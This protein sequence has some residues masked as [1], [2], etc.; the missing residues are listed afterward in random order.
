MLSYNRFLSYV[1]HG[2]NEE[3]F[4]PITDDPEYD[5]FVS[6]YKSKTGGEFFI[7]WT[8]RNIRRK[9]PSDVILAFKLFCDMLPKEEALKCVLMLHTDPVDNNGTDLPAVIDAI[10]PEYKVAFSPKKVD[11]KT[12]NYMYNLASA[13]INISYAEGWGLSSHESLMA[14]T[15][16]IGNVTGGIQDQ[17]GFV[18]E[19]GELVDPSD[20]T[21][22]WQTNADGK[23]TKHGEWCIALFPKIRT[24][25]GSP[26]TPYIY[27]DYCSVN[28]VADAIKSIYDMPVEERNRLGLLGR[29][30]CLDERTGMSSK[31]MCN[32]MIKCIDTLYKDYTKFIKSAD[33]FS[34][35]KVEYNRLDKKSS[36]INYD[37]SK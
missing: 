2:I 18:K 6:D 4:Y 7:F 33:K 5:K 8:N 21:S 19:D 23:Y 10:C 26:P 37:T 14:G 11:T 30:Y 16:I 1:P 9:R 29:E 17:M 3:L 13:T 20:Y 28:E 24:L 22:E 27:E 36:E 15:M 34:F 32:R 12:M 35:E 25:V 31:N